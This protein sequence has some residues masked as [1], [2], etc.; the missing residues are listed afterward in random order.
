MNTQLEPFPKPSTR[1]S[2]KLI[3]MSVLNK[4]HRKFANVPKDKFKAQWMLIQSTQTNMSTIND[5]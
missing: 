1:L 2:W 5:K 3:R 4:D